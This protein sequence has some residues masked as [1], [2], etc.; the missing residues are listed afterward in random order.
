MA[1]TDFVRVTSTAA[2]QTFSPNLQPGLTYPNPNP[3]LTLTL[4]TGLMAA[5]D[6]VRVTS[7]VAAQTFNLYPQKGHII[8][9]SDA[10]IIVFDPE[11]VSPSASSMLACTVSMPGPCHADI[12]V[13][14][15]RG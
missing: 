2:A 14:N 8:A 10:D 11:R 1:A 6:F 4:P 15:R 3:N 13:F 5:T 7:T 12:I 9:G